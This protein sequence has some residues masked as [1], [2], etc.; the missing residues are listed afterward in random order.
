MLWQERPGEIVVAEIGP[1]DL[2]RRQTIPVGDPPI[3]VA[4]FH[5]AVYAAW[6]AP[7]GIRGFA[8]GATGVRSFQVTATGV[9]V[10]AIG[11]C[12]KAPACVAWTDNRTGHL[13][14]LNGALKPSNPEELI[15]GE[16]VG[17]RPTVISAPRPL[18]WVSSMKVEEGEPARWRSVVTG[19]GTPPSGFEGLVHSVAWFR[20]R[21]WAA[22]PDGLRV[23]RQS[24][25]R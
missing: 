13:V 9:Q 21:L 6:V 11:E 4:S 15:L 2:M 5:G 25:R 24:G 8:L 22:G 3:A 23:F 16:A 10:I 17:G 20:D 19:P 14:R 12:G 7:T 1:K 18:V